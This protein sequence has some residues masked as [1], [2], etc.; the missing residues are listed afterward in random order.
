ML[1][2]ATVVLLLIALFTQS[3]GWLG[4]GILVYLI[5]VGVAVVGWGL[6]VAAAALP[7]IS[8][9]GGLLLSFVTGPLE[10]PIWQPFAVATILLFAVV[11]TA[12]T[13]SPTSSDTTDS[14]SSSSDSAEV[15]NVEEL[16][17]VGEQKG[18]TTDTESSTSSDSSSSD[19][20][21]FPDVE[22]LPGIGA[23]KGAALRDAGYK[24]ASDILAATKSELTTIDGIGT[25]IAARLLA[26]VED[27]HTDH[28][29]T[30][31]VAGL[32]TTCE[33]IEILGGTGEVAEANDRLPAAH[34]AVSETRESLN[35]LSSDRDLRLRVNDVEDRLDAIPSDS[36][37]RHS[38]FTEL[39]EGGDAH[40]TKARDAIEDGE[41]YQGLRACEAARSAY[42]DAQRIKKKTDEIPANEKT[43][44][45]KKQLDTVE[46]LTD[47]LHEE[48]QVQ[49]VET[50]IEKLGQQV[51]S[52]ADNDSAQ[53]PQKAANSAVEDAAN[54]LTH[55]PDETDSRDL[56]R[57]ITKSH[58]QV[59]GFEEIAEQL[60]TRSPSASPNTDSDD[61]PAAQ[62]NSEKSA[63]KVPTQADTK[64]AT[65]SVD[66]GQTSRATQA[67]EIPSSVV[68]T[69]DEI[70]DTAELTETVILQI[71]EQLSESGRRSVFRANTVSGESVQL[72]V[73]NWHV[74]EFTLEP[75]DWY[76]FDAVR[77]Q[78]WTVDGTS[79]VTISTTPNVT[80]TKHGP[81]PDHKTTTTEQP[82]R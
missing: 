78:H 49:Q 54:A 64:S 48:K 45:I 24:D 28:E 33:R 42:E 36:E 30:R 14:T 27:Q 80:I 7:V 12:D 23:Q 37:A 29:K 5:S 38:K 2:T 44:S 59:S 69:V 21:G 53:D 46:S 6:N 73:W 79:G 3:D 70:P 11:G 9:W 13:E 15:P 39:I 41:V 72:D 60:T 17:R 50:A 75:D 40:V 61:T 56:Q 19:S 22:E 58:E 66:L 82:R 26:S 1:L 55:L 31:L 68:R 76:V 74:S 10:L 51:D 77:G 71:R 65:E 20:R 52:A 81:T 32:E 57:R 63:A 16:P 18:G 43:R 8:G 67:L 4:F 35:T 25:A 47:R 34:A 62:I